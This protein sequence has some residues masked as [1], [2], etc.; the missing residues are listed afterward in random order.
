MF[1]DIEPA[2]DA[3]FVRAV[4]RCRDAGATVTEIEIPELDELPEMN[5]GGGFPAAEAYAWHHDLIVRRGADYDPRVLVRIRRGEGQSARD[6]VIL[7]QRRRA[8]I[9]GVRG[10]LDG[11]DAFICPTVPLVAPPLEVFDDDAEY[12]RINVLML[13][14]PTVVNLLDGCAA[15]VP[16]QDGGEPPVGLMVAGLAG[17]DAEVLRIA[18]WIEE[19]TC[20]S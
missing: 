12:A 7:H 17:E 2:V 20:R 3:A 9:E 16:I 8:M 10:R 6:L 13:R 14:N 5:A 15:S 18:A 1:A 19:Q 11:F 4:A